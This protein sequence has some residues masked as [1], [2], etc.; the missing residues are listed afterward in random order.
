MPS[1]SR[2]DTK[3]RIAFDLAAGGVGDFFTLDDPVLGVLDTGP[4]GLAGDVLEDVTA[5]VRSV[6]VRRGRSRELERFTAGAATVVLDNTG[7]KYDPAAGTAITPYGASMRPRKAVTVSVADVPILSGVVDDWNLEYSL[8]KNHTATVTVTDGFAFLA[9]QLIDPHTTTGQAS[10]ARVTAILDRSEINWPAGRR[11]IDTGNATLQADV[12]GP[13]PVNALAYL[14]KVDEAE[15]GALFIGATGSLVFRERAALQLLSSTT[16]ADDGSGIPYTAISASYGSEELRNRITVTVLNG[17]TA[18]AEDA[19]S[20]TDYGGI[21]YAIRDTLLADATQAQSLADELL[22]RYSVPR[23]RI[24]G[25]EVVLNDLTSAQVTEIIGL[26]LGD[27]VRIIFTPSGIGNALD[28]FAQLDEIAHTID[29][30]VHRVRLS[31]SNGQP[32]ALVLDSPTMGVLDT[33]I[34]GI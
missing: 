27:L 22:N 26:E 17:G 28:Q 2:P 10:G 24:D 13:E 4:E 18:T 31:F 30:G 12:I 9:Q 20:V 25:V 5:D 33:D 15:Q 7:R 1:M 19:T 11:D 3:V 21:D 34:L 32:Q 29:P 14:Q 16:F 6:T 8:D 23:L